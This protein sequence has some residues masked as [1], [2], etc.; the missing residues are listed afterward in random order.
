MISENSVKLFCCEAAYL[1]ENYD[2][3]ISDT[4]QIWHCHHRNE[5]AMKK[6]KDELIQLGLYYDRPADELIFLTPSEHSSLH[7]K[8]MT[9]E[10]KQ[11]LS[12]AASI[13]NAMKGKHLSTEH[14]SKISASSKGRVFSEQTRHKLSAS[15]KN[16]PLPK[17]R[18]L[19]PTGEIT[20]MSKCN[21]ANHH[22]DWKLLENIPVDQN[23]KV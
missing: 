8:N 19:T 15:L 21:A 10:H 2:Q 18:W 3:A 16:R 12:K 1:I 11:K 6:S 5:I 20:I 14:K 4:T 7:A 23:E 17:Y 9:D 13:K 22:P